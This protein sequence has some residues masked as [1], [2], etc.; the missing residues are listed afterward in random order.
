MKSELAEHEEKPSFKFRVARMPDESAKKL[1]F[2]VLNLN[3]SERRESNH[4]F[5]K[6]SVTLRSESVAPP[7][8]T[9]WLFLD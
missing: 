7:F 2:F 5:R 3:M 8:R 4:S 1:G 9:Q 6:I